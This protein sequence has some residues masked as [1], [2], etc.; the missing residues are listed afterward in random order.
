[1]ILK[2]ETWF[3]K[4]DA[5]G[6]YGFRCCFADD[7]PLECVPLPLDG[8]CPFRPFDVPSIATIS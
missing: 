3:K 8:L 7:C 4:S 5:L 6:A 2:F 1:M